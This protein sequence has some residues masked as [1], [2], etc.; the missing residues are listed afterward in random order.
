MTTFFNANYPY[1]LRFTRIDFDIPE[2]AESTTE[3]LF[4]VGLTHG[5][6]RAL[7]LKYYSAYAGTYGTGINVSTQLTPQIRYAVASHYINSLLAIVPP[8]VYNA[9]MKQLKPFAFQGVVQITQMSMDEY[10]IYKDTRASAEDL[11]A[12]RKL[13][14]RRRLV[15]NIINRLELEVAASKRK[16][17]SFYTQHEEKVPVLN[18][19]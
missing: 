4:E 11:V 14:R 2:V 3:D 5:H 13:T 9:I 16:I 17:E 6:S 12:R 18:L 8:D 7:V 10:K 19:L 15:V 1:A